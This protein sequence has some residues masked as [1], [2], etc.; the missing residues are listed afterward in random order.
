MVTPSHV[1][2]LH[3]AIGAVGS[4]PSMSIRGMSIAAAFG[5]SILPGGNVNTRVAI[6][7]V[8]WLEVKANHLHWHDGEILQTRNML[9]GGVDV[10][11]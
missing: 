8:D 2:S 9:W 10:F 6:K 1:S 3:M 5:G 4:M 7:K 11:G